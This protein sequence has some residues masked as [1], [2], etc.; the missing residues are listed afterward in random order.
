MKMSLILKFRGQKK[1]NNNV[2]NKM[3]QLHKQQ[4]PTYARHC[5]LFWV[6]HFVIL[7]TAQSQTL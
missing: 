4:F 6:Q 1:L 7:L 5:T 2:F 3:Y